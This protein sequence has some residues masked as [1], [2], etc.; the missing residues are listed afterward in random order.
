[1]L[2]VLFTRNRQRLGDLLARTVVVE[3][4]PEAAEPVNGADDTP[5]Q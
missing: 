1:M 5:Q 3:L 2:A 4:H